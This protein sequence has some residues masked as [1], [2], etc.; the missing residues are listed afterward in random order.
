MN[1]IIP[2]SD[3]RQDE[4]VKPQP[5]VRIRKMWSRNSGWAQYS[6]LYYVDLVNQFG[7][8]CSFKL[9]EYGLGENEALCIATNQSH[10][11]GWTIKRFEEDRK[12]TVVLKELPS[13]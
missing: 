8:P 10:F 9:H 12:T 1:T 4:A 13:P 11:F 5:Y 7:V 2:K 3:I 6:W